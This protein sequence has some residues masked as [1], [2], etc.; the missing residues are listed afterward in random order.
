M[1]VESSYV[2]E[3]AAKGI[4]WMFESI[5]E[6]GKQT[7][8]NNMSIPSKTYLKCKLIDLNPELKYIWGES[9]VEIE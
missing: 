8:Y 6:A 9:L 7:Q 2:N 3:F 5:Q 4:K 1:E